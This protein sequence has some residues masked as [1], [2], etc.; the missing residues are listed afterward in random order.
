MKV[1]LKIRLAFKQILGIIGF[2]IG[3]ERVFSLIN[4]LTILKCYHFYKW[5]IGLNYHSDKKIGL[6]TYNWIVHQTQT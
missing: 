2:Q 3:I 5:K 1:S 4:V 6:M